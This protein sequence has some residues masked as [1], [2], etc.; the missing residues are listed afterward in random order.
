MDEGYLKAPEQDGAHAHRVS[1]QQVEEILQD[2]ETAAYRRAANHAVDEKDHLLVTGQVQQRNAF[3]Q[4]L[5]HRIY[6]IGHP[7]RDKRARKT[8][9]AEAGQGRYHSAQHQQE[10]TLDADKREAVQHIHHKDVDDDGKEGG[11]ER[12]YRSLRESMISLP[13]TPLGANRWP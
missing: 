10:Q 2:G 5:H 8:E 11:Y 12:H 4:L 9:Q 13:C 6:I 7:F 1:Q 3:H